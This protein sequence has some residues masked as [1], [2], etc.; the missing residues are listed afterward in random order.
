MKSLGIFLK[1]AFAIFVFS[2]LT[3]CGGG[4]GGGD[5]QTPTTIPATPSALSI[6][7]SSQSQVDLSWTDN[8]SNET[9]FKVER[10]EGLSGTYTVLAIIPA[11]S[12]SYSDTSVTAG[13]TYI[14]RLRAY[15]SAGDSSYTNEAT[16]N[17]SGVTPPLPAAPTSLIAT[18]ISASQ[19]DLTWTDNATDETGFRLE[20]KI[21][22]AGVY[23]EIKTF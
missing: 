4:G 3:A 5:N 11:N 13:I 21:G 22:A 10:K 7:S 16:V 19:V 18:A 2:V 14:Y 8:A 20:R 15:N 9:G 12:I 1:T 6:Q 17:I 23:S